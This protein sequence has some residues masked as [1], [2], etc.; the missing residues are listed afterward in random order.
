MSLTPEDVKKV[1]VL[2]RLEFSESE[3]AVFTEQLG[4]IVAFVEQLSEVR[5]EGV[6]AMA[7]PLDVHSVLR[8]DKLRPGLSREAA[9]S[10]SPNHDDTCFLVPPVM[11]RNH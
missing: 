4:K 7:H 2:A 10:N 11:A 9:L 3:I 8:A 6:E 1:A 5:T